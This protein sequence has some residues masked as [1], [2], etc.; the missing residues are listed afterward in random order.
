MLEGAPTVQWLQ[1]STATRRSHP[2][3]PP[4]LVPACPE[5]C[6]RHVLFGYKIRRVTAID[7]KSTLEGSTSPIPNRSAIS[8]SWKPWYE[9]S[10]LDFRVRIFV[11][12]A[13]CFGVRLPDPEQ[14]C[15][16]RLFEA[17][18]WGFGFQDSGSGFRVPGF[19]FQVSGFRFQVSGFRFRAQGAECRVQDAGLG[20][21]H[22]ARRD[23]D[24]FHL[25][26][27]MK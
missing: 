12:R 13:S 23:E 16:Q 5:A 19:R 6:T 7:S 14:I 17:L 22:L 8:D 4:R 27:E 2:A 10:E 21:V 18:G 1:R 9:V 15:D 20:D 11:C 3:A 25:S 26:I 24:Q